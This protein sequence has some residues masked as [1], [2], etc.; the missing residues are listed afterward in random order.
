MVGLNVLSDVADDVDRERYLAELARFLHGFDPA[1][2]EVL[3]LPFQTGVNPS[4]DLASVREHVLPGLPAG[5]ATTADDVDLHSIGEQLARCDVLV[6]MRFHSLLL[7]T[8][9]GVPFVGLSYDPKC[10]RYLDAIDHPHR[11]ELTELDAAELRSV[12]DTVLGRAAAERR[13][14]E[15][16]AAREFAAGRRWREQV[17]RQLA[18]PVA[19]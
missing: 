9:H 6:G 12:V 18:E 2:F 4:N 13:R 7:A 17:R 3:L 8:A 19:G 15:D 5:L 11:V 14:L 1:R 16:V 10:R